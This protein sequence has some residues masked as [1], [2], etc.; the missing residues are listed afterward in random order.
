MALI[1]K[2]DVDDYFAA[3]RAT[4]LGRNSPA[5]KPATVVT[6]PA[7]KTTNAPRLIGNRTR[8]TSSPSASSASIPIPSDFGRS[9]LLRP[10]GSRQE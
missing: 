6:E 3:K 2:I 9:R 1:K 7:K 5:S 8:E 10:L 4:R